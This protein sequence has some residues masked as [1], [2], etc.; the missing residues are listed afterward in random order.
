MS[1]KSWNI[2]ELSNEAIKLAVEQKFSP[3]FAQILLNRNINADSLGAFLNPSLEA[4][5]DPFDLPD[6][7][8]AVEVIKGTLNRGAK[9]LV[10]GDYDVDG[11]TSLAIFHEYIKDYPGQYQ[12]YIPHRVHDG[13]G[14]SKEA[15]DKARE[16]GAG[17]L[18]A[19]DCGTNSVVEV[20]YATMHKIDVVVIDHHHPQDD[21]NLPLAFV[22]AKRKDSAYPF[23]ELSSGALSF[24]LLQALTG[25][26]NYE[27]LGLAAISIVC[28]VVPLV[29]ENRIIL[30]QGLD[31]LQGSQLPAIRALCEAVKIDQSSLSVFH[32]G[33][34]LGPRIN[35]SGRVA[36]AQD[37]LDLFLSDDIIDARAAAVKLCE[38]NVLR[39]AIELDIFKAADISAAV[40]P[41]CAAVVACGDNWHPGV[42]GIVASRLCEKYERPAFVISFDGD[43]GKGS[44]RSIDGLHLMDALSAC[45]TLLTEYGGHKKAAGISLH[46]DNVDEFKLKLNEIIK[47]YHVGESADVAINI[48]ARLSFADVNL[49]LVHELEQLKPFGEGNPKA[50]FAAFD[51]LKKSTPRKIKFGYTVWLSCGG[52]TYEATFYD[53][54]FVALLEGGEKFNILFNL[55]HNTYHNTP[56]IALKDIQIV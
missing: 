53:E 22:N 33:F 51:V 46:K 54:D 25:K 34:V 38:Y 7:D 17:L 15:V 41:Q 6:M 32:L 26:I 44:C 35:A 56:R 47:N 43:I 11:V 49:V 5:H 55:E 18:V 29:G 16:F 48:D 8:K 1:S 37:A 30:K 27:A 40:T 50:L 19:F 14:L 24:K 45:G 36:H 13:Y 12:F 20:E 42:L 10:A 9:I 4:L 21:F 3:I 39:K 52:F 23:S 31:Q 2:R 28:D